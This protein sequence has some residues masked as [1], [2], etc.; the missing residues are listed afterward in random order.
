VF[1]D[2]LLSGARPSGCFDPEEICSLGG[3]EAELRAAGITVVAH[4][5]R[6]LKC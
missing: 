3:V 5:H 6:A 2:V 4:D 1:A